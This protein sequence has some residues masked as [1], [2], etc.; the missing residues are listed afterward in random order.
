MKP[1]W[2]VYQA[3]DVSDTGCKI[4]LLDG[5]MVKDPLMFPSLDELHRYMKSFHATPKEN[6]TRHYKLRSGDSSTPKHP[7]DRPDEFWEKQDA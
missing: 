7:Y 6:T 4:W 2:E 1:I 5:P 3:N